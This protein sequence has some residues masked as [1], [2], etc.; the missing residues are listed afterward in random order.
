M[1]ENVDLAEV[2]FKILSS[3]MLQR[4]HG[5]SKALSQVSSY[6]FVGLFV[7][8]TILLPKWRSCLRKCRNKADF[9][10]VQH[11]VKVPHRRRVFHYRP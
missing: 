1:F 6:I 11:K 8:V 7:F 10:F 5:K 9:K 3:Y 4:T 2:Y